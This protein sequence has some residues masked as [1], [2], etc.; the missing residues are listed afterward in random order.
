M[1][2]KSPIITAGSGS[3]GG[4]TVAHNAGGLYF[5][6]RSTPTDP[7]TAQQTLIRNAF[8][9]LSNYW[10]S[11]LTAQ[12]RTEWNIYASNV[13]VLDAF[14]DAIYISGF[15]HFMRSNVMYKKN[16]GSVLADGPANFN[17]GEFTSPVPTMSE[18]AQQISLTY[19]DAD[20][21]VSEDGACL[22]VYQSRPQNR[23][24]NFFKGPYQLAGV[25]LGSAAAPP[26]SPQLL[27]AVFPF[28]EDQRVFLRFAV[29]RV[30]GRLS[31][32]Y[33]TFCLAVA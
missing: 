7:G 1:K 3:V 15:N 23:T 30:D 8:A 18:A 19:G 11:T 21:W 20:D 2:F 16:F 27:A 28:V 12:Q 33:R 10:L 29:S 26:A 5:R 4:L 14:G 6:G 25:I 32:S 13:T 24:I 22:W 9:F 31:A 17:L